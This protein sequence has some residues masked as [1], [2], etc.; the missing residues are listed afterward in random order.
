MVPSLLMEENGRLYQRER[1][2]ESTLENSLHPRQRDPT[3]FRSLREDSSLRLENLTNKQV[4]ISLK[5]IDGRNT[6]I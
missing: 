6:L 3:Q 5:D 2:E 1:Q 4:I